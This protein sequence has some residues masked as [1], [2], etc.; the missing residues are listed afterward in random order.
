MIDVYL[1][2]GFL[3]SGKTSGLV[4]LIE[5]V[6]Q[7]GR[8]PAVLM[9]EFGEMNIDSQIVE[10][11]GE[12]PLKELLNGCI[13]CSGAESTEAQI[14][15]LLADYPHVDVL[16]IETTGAAHPVEA[17]DAVYSP[18]FAAQL[19]VKGIITIVDAKR[20]I[21]RDALSPRM[22]AL[23]LEQIRH[24]HFMVLNKT[25]LLS[26]DELATVTMQVSQLNPYAPLVQTVNA[27][28]DFRYIEKMIDA[29]SAPTHEVQT[30]SGL[31]IAS[32]VLTFDQPV[33]QEHFE[34]WVRTLPDTIY[35]MKGY[36]QLEGSRYSHL[37]QYAYGMVQW[38]P[39]YIQ[40][41]STLVIIGEQLQHVKY[42]PKN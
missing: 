10:D 16:F 19:C 36:I 29:S 37:F 13:C 17:L 31:P 23:F 8:L 14:Q 21:D 4:Q 35:R 7:S 40:L 24:A 33:D 15:S 30:G 38:I 41:P 20:W 12:V 2:S 34:A 27:K 42:E 5:Q 11:T 26:D 39:E 22:L 28:V 25:D 3:G 9:N 6:K 18:L 1:L 32:K